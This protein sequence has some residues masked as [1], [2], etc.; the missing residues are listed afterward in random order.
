MSTTSI[1]EF[2]TAT[3]MGNCVRLYLGNGYPELGLIVATKE[4]GHWEY[5]NEHT[6]RE[7]AAEWYRESFGC[8]P[9]T[10]ERRGGNNHDFFVFRCT[11][12]PWTSNGEDPV[13]K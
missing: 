1:V 11:N 13:N 10:V 6:C 8:R 9:T 4:L 12:E 3:I 2:V 7:C 5:R